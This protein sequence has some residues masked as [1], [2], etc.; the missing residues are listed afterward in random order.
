MPMMRKSKI[1]LS[2]SYPSREH[3]PRAECF[4]LNILDFLIMGINHF[5]K[6]AAY[7]HECDRVGL[8]AL[9]KHYRPTLSGRP[10]VGIDVRIGYN[11]IISGSRDFLFAHTRAMALKVFKLYEHWI[12]NGFDIIFIDDNSNPLPSKLASF[13]R[14]FSKDA[15]RRKIPQVLEGL[16]TAGP[17]NI[18]EARKAASKV[19]KP[20]VLLDLSLLMNSNKFSHICSPREC[21]ISKQHARPIRNSLTCLPVAT[22]T[23]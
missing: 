7:Q 1:F 11:I 17:D 15:N 23:S 21:H 2:S 18:E 14:R 10:I 13:Q 12:H 22:S 4:E 19:L 8:F 3:I 5:W 9:I 16:R 20:L 6:H